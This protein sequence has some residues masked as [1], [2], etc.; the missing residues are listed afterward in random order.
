MK[1]LRTFEEYRHIKIY[2]SKDNVKDE[3]EPFFNEP[4]YDYKRRKEIFGTKDLSID[5]IKI[6]RRVINNLLNEKDL[7]DDVIFV[8]NKIKNKLKERIN[9]GVFNDEDEPY[10]VFEE[11]SDV[12]VRRI[13]KMGFGTYIYDDS[14]EYSEYFGD[15]Y[16]ISWEWK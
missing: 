4:K 2:P 15:K 6:D 9:S 8:L 16:K 12:D 14:N 3:N 10:I 5:E 7:S 11:L 1:N 13:R